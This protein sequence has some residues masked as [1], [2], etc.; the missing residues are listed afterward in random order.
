MGR[1]ADKTFF[2]ALRKFMGL[3]APRE[4]VAEDAKGERIRIKHTSGFN[5]EGNEAGLYA[6]INA[7]RVMSE[8]HTMQEAIARVLELKAPAAVQKRVN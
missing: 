3:N 6:V 2:G 5:I 7:G 8:G 1:A 4:F